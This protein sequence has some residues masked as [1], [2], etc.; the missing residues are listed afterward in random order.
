MLG[1]VFAILLA[2]TIFLLKEQ[3]LWAVSYYCDAIIPDIS[4][5]C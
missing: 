1:S 3:P 4:E 5:A 2:Y